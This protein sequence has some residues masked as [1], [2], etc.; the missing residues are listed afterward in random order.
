MEQLGG[1]MFAVGGRKPEK[2]EKDFEMPFQAETRPRAQ[3]Q[4]QADL[5][6]YTET[7]VVPYW[8]YRAGVWHVGRS[9]GSK[10]GGSSGGSVHVAVS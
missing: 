9:S 5:A 6:M 4:I 10:E 3:G 7:V 8:Q 2:G 1:C